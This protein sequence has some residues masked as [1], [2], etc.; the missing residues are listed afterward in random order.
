ISLGSIGDTSVRRKIYENLK[1][2]GFKF[3]SIIDKPAIVS[4]NS[5]IE[6]GVFIG[7]GAIVNSNATI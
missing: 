3:P 2:I 5:T 6:E 4:K 7:K 1:S